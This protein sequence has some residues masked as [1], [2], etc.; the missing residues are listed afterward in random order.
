VDKAEILD[1][2]ELK[3]KRYF[4]DFRRCEGC[5]Q[6]YWRGSHYDR[7]QAFIDQALAAALRPVPDQ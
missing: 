5:G 4:N 7:M 1:Q 3:T 2:L 6:I